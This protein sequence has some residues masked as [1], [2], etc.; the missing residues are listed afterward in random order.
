MTAT[1][2]VPCALAAGALLLASASGQATPWQWRDAQGRMV[3]SDRAPPA[4]VRSSQILRSP[5]VAQPATGSRSAASS[6]AEAPSAVEAAASPAKASA[7]ATPT[8]VERE[9]AFRQ[10][11]AEREAS[12][13]KQREDSERAASTK[14]ACDEAQREIRNLESG[15]RVVTLNARGEP[16]P[17]DDVQRAQRLKTARSD[18]GRVCADR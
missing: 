10:R 11:M 17:L 14:R 18:L 9:R 1:R 7:G 5:V 8:W 16:E 6:P 2:F 12:E 15:R 4:D 13:A 3:Y